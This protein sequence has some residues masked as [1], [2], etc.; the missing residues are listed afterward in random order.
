MRPQKL[1]PLLSFF[2]FLFLGS[3]F[4]FPISIYANTT[5][6]FTITSGVD[7]S[8]GTP[9][10]FTSNDLQKLSASDSEPGNG[11]DRMRSDKW[12]DEN[13]YDESRY[14]EF[15]FSP[16]IPQDAIISEVK[17]THEFQRSA[18]LVVAKIE[19]W[20]GENF[21]DQEGTTLGT[22]G[23]DH[24]DVIDITSVLNT[25]AKINNAK[26][27]FLTYRAT[28]TQ[29][30]TTTGHDFVG[31]SV[32]YDTPLPPDNF[33]HITDDITENT[34][35]TLDN[36]PYVVESDIIVAD[37]ITLTI[38]PGII[39]K[40]DHASI[41]VLGSVNANGTETEP[42]YFTSIYND[43]RGGDTNGDGED[44][45]P[46][47]YDEWD[48]GV[49]GATA[50][51]SFSHTF[52]EYLNGGL[53]VD[54]GALD[55]A[56][57][58]IQEAGEGIYS[59]AGN[60]VLDN[61]S[62]SNIDRDAFSVDGGVAEIKDSSV[63]NI[64]FGDALG[65]YGGSLN[66]SGL[67]VK[68]IGF[69]SAL[70]IY[71][72]NAIVEDSIFEGGLDAGIELYGGSLNF[73]DSLLSGYP[74]GNFA[75][76]GGASTLDR[77]KVENTDY[78]ISVYGGIVTLSNS[79]FKEIFVNAVENYSDFTIKAQN[80]FWG[81]A[82]GPYHEVSN[83]EGLGA[84]I[85][86]DVLFDPWCKN[87]TCIIAPI[88]NPVIIVP[89]VLGT[90]INKPTEN[91]LEKL[92]L[93]L[94]HNLTDIGDQFMDAL[95][96][97]A[98]LT[99]SDTSLTI[100][101]VIGKA[102]VTFQNFNIKLFDYSDG[103]LNEFK[104]Q[105]YIEGV[106]LFLF[107][108]DWRYGVNEDNVN[109]LKQKIINVLAQT[110]TGEVDI[111]AHS[112]G[113]L[114]VK[115]YVVE[116]PENNHIDKAV[117]VGVPNTG[118][119]KAFKALI[120]GDSFG[121]FLV[122]ESEMKKISA[123]FPVA[124]DLS[125]SEQYFNT[126]G[127]YAKIIDQYNFSNKIR[128]LDFEESNIFLIDDHKLNAQAL[129]NA[130]KLHT[131]DFDN[132]DMRTAGI[133]LYAVDGCKAGTIG[134]FVEARYHGILGGENYIISNF[135]IEETPGD[136]TVPLESSTNLPI[137]QANKYY[138]LKGKH[139]DMLSQDGARQQIVNIISNSALSTQ[140][141]ITQD[142]SKCKLN[143][144]AISVFSPLSIDVLDQDGNHLGLASDGVSIEN[145]I[146]NADFQIIDD[147]KFVYLPTDEGQTYT[148]SV[149]GA[150]TGTF[151][152][153]DATIEENN[154]TQ[155]QVFSNISVTPSLLGHINISATTTLTLDIDGNG[156]IDQTLTLNSVL[157]ATQSQD[158][159]PDPPAS[160]PPVDNP[161]TATI[162]SSGSRGGH[163]FIPIISQNKT[164][165]QNI[166][167]PSS[168]IA[169][170]SEK[171]PILKQKNTFAVISPAKNTEKTELI[172]PPIENKMPENT[173]TANVGD[174]ST[175]INYKIIEITLA[176]FIVILL[177]VKKFI[178]V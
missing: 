12:P 1:I 28:V 23:A 129:V 67:T 85:Y 76:Y 102:T 124:Y 64:D 178:K 39:I 14:I 37:G 168:V 169:E 21:I 65:L 101:D 151:T 30:G 128:N 91:G 4:I 27:R 131:A 59:Y 134:K 82:S 42:I 107:P 16:D 18:A 5:V 115:K 77:L 86:G 48:I 110:N 163:S 46:S 60:V 20:D 43:A 40:F 31:L 161:Q 113:G 145:N 8:S 167:V 61:V 123:N 99:P 150:G 137:D 90:E 22:G 174:S 171:T 96:F 116:N 158:F 13:Q 87:E 89:G 38:E 105:G 154:V 177:V 98:D 112:T 29:S 81:D 122:A 155:T 7:A 118:A 26:I 136:G 41:G 142:I 153:T 141:I 49:Y 104:D 71:A 62:I 95:Q 133:D 173:L 103:L 45:A 138:A 94:E 135:K 148:I 34:T 9:K 80:N 143:G 57:T 63:E 100:G 84:S 117:F 97:N 88:R 17:I 157:N 92:W 10:S 33:T 172:P 156:T 15:I 132:Y 53:Y 166:P 127:S 109:K 119:P 130:H 3:F 44:T 35:W 78:G 162:I 111:I 149:A 79:A 36:S 108:Y 147:H 152:I 126:K 66:V 146:P 55:L 50:K 75:S 106:D 125:P 54:N 6:D 120:Q 58:S 74:S 51:I 121:N 176:G 69:G 170:V 25:A 68:N 139:G 19:V 83:P 165:V 72:G 2:V 93:D 175:P 140:D 56:Y 11:V 24:T 70:G 73:Y 47:R 114:L 160:N 52:V 144:R 159:I 164:T 32:T